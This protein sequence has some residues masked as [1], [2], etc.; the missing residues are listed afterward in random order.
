MSYVCPRFLG[1]WAGCVCMS[2]VRLWIEPSFCE[3]DLDICV[4]ST[5]SQERSHLDHIFPFNLRFKK[6]SLAINF[7]GGQHSMKALQTI[8]EHC[9]KP[10]KLLDTEDYDAME[11]CRPSYLHLFCP[12]I[13]ILVTIVY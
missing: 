9:E 7:V 2:V 12:C 5:L 4:L 8:K 13:N 6:S 10:F 11:N 1:L 3:S